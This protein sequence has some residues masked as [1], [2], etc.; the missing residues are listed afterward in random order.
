MALNLQPDVVRSF[1]PEFFL[2]S[3]AEV[4][5]KLLG[6]WL[7]RRTKHGFCGGPIVEAEAYIREDPACHAYRGKTPR[8]QVMWGPPGRAYVYFIYGNYYCF[9]VVCQRD[10]VAEAVL[11]RAIEPVFDRTWMLEHRA[12]SDLRQLTSGPGKLCLAMNIGREHNGID[13][14]DVSQPVV[15]GLNPDA[16]TF[17]RNFGPVITTTR[18]GL[19][20]AADLPLRFYLDGC[21]SVSRRVKGLLKKPEGSRRKIR[22]S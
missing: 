5:P 3:A 20:A 22:P 1:S 17:R 16:A 21:F 4:A 15:L 14:C 8:N 2:P 18:I 9:N 12:V 11:V 7:L 6:H 13:L 19:S 10:G